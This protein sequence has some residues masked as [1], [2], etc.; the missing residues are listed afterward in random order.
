[1]SKPAARE[2]AQETSVFEEAQPVLEPEAAPAEGEPSALEAL[3]A[4]MKAMQEKID[5][6]EGRQSEAYPDDDMLF[7]AKPS[8]EQWSDRVLDLATKSYVEVQMSAT[9][10]YGPFASNEAV[11][12]YIGA[13]Q[14]KRP[15]DGYEWDGVRTVTGR[16]KRSIEAQERAER[17]RQGTGPRLPSYFG[18]R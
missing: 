18:A 3:M 5:R 11:A 9:A 15:N 8:G 6:L 14:G 16:E 17:D 12:A 4:T 2:K 7:I 1:M 13:K 10:F